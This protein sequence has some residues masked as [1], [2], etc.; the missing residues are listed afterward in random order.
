[1]GNPRHVGASGRSVADAA[2]RQLVM[3]DCVHVADW[4]RPSPLRPGLH[5]ANVYYRCIMLII[6][7]LST[8]L[9]G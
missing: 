7:A 3:R 1:M 8:F 9:P 5:A 6:T 4:D 2:V